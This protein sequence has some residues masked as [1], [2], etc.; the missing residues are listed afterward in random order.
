MEK[1]NFFFPEKSIK[2]NQNDKPW[3]DA[4]LLKLDRAWK[5]EYNNNKK[6]EKWLKLN[7][8]FL[9]RSKELKES[10]YVNMV[11]DLKTSNVGQ[12]YS[13]VKRMSSVDPTHDDKVLVEELMHLPSSD[14]A[15]VIANKFA[16]ISNLYEPL[17]SEDI[18]I[19]DVENSKPVPLFEPFQIYEKIQKMKKKTSSVHGDIPW[20]VILE[21]SV[22]L[23]T[24]LSNLYNCS[25]LAGIWPSIWKH[26]YI[27]PVPKVHPPADTDDLRKISGT[28]NLSKIY[29]ALMSDFIIDDMSQNIDPAQYGNEK[30]LSIQHYLVKLVNRI[31]TILD[32]NNDE[33]KYAVLA[34]LV[35]WSKAFDRQDPKIGIES[36]INNGVRPTL[37]P[38]LVSYFQE[39]KMSVK[40]HG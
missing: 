4:K 39:R 18:L 14:Q 37:I 15:E 12:W 20:R 1:V 2:L 19:P 9:E 35:D 34:Q 36:F 28:K 26:E 24:P 11:E 25:S 30:G 38:L 31:L 7:E 17:R 10:Y 5:R 23:S 29:E 22:E 27:T 6:S 16:E 8:E 32:T 13:K 3:V 33:E 40:W 21:F